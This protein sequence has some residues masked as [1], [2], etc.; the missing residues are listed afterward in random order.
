MRKAQRTHLYVCEPSAGGAGK[1]APL[2]ALQ[3]LHR[4]PVCI[5]AGANNTLVM[6]KLLLMRVLSAL[7]S[8]IA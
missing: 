4:F 2:P 8:F 5:L 6:P 7:T 3:L 1:D